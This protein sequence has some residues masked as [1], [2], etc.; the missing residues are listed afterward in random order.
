[1][2][3]LLLSI[4]FSGLVIRSS[5][6]EDEV[7]HMNLEQLM[8]VKVSTASI[9]DRPVREQPGIVSVI[10]E[11]EIR[12]SGAEYLM[13]LLDQVPGYSVAHDTYGGLGLQFRGLWAHEG[14]TLLIVDGIP[15]NEP[16]FGTAPL[17][18]L[19]PTETIRQVEVIRGPG[20]T[21]YGGNAE[22]TVIRVLTK[23]SEMHGGFLSSTMTYSAGKISDSHALGYGDQKG[24]W[25]WA[26]NAS[27]DRTFWSTREFVDQSGSR[28]SMRHASDATPESLNFNLGYKGLDLR[29]L[30]ENVTYEGMIGS[31]TL[32]PSQQEN[33]FETLALKAS[34]EWKPRSWLT[35]TPRLEH[36]ISRAWQTKSAEGN[37][38]NGVY[39]DLFATEAKADI[40]DTS[41]LLTGV[42]WLRQTGKT[43]DR[44]LF[45]QDASTHFEGR[46]SVAYDIWS[47]YSQ[48]E[49]ETPWVNFT[50]GGR[51]EHHSRIGGS[52]VPRLGI[53]KAWERWHA[54]LLYSQSY[55]T[56]NIEVI[57][58]PL[59]SDVK[60]EDTRGYELEVGRQITDH[61]SWLCNVY[62]MQVR[63]ALV[64]Q[65]D[66]LNQANY[67]YLNERRLSTYGVESE[68]RLKLSHWQ[69]RL[70]YANYFVDQ[71]TSPTYQSG[72]SSRFLG[73]PTHKISSSMSWSPIEPLTWTLNGTLS[74]R[75]LAYVQA[76]GSTDLPN[77]FL[78]N[79]L[80]EY[81]WKQMKFGVGVHNLLDEDHWFIQPYQGG[82][83]PLPGRGRE[84]FLRV[85]WEF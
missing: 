46:G 75:R 62:Y 55:R 72:D 83:A 64:Y 9:S 19:L 11:K 78:L 47:A 50:L 57:A 45:G 48:F 32:V 12:S 6:S 70:S 38:L 69:G 4:V 24:N 25:R 17:V 43:W 80:V 59:G 10:S 54:K 27:L 85:R 40:S 73:A 81:R 18:F 37:D 84:Y 14:K 33:E 23:G 51:Y 20:S 77:Q 1:M 13:D 36:T 29:L 8:Q 5:A 35:I 63:N 71:N 49:Q 31:G 52:F 65:Q 82:F 56:P 28:Y 2:T 74:S 58:S 66:P 15:V 16:M 22:L 34:Y 30:Y 7:F 21:R 53:T 76:S 3:G 68:L 41:K 79:T 42:E 60:A 61:L 39:S 26:V 44:S 67:G